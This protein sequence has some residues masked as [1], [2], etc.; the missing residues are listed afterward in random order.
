MLEEEESVWITFVPLAQHPAATD[1]L[2]APCREGHGQRLGQTQELQA[3]WAVG[4]G[5]SH[6][7]RVQAYSSLLG[8]GV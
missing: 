5:E 7:T 6:R 1:V 2:R 3:A 8:V 4:R